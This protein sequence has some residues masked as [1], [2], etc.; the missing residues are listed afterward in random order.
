MKIVSVRHGFEADHS[1]SNYYFFALERLSKEQREAIAALTDRQ[2]RGRTLEF[3]YWGDYSMPW[4][5]SEKLLTMG[6][7]IL[8]SESY[9]WWAVHLSLPY[10]QDLFERIGRYECDYDGNGINV[11]QVG[12]RM[13]VYFGFSMDYGAAYGAMGDDPFDGL[14]DLFEKIRDELLAGDLGAL[15]AVYDVYGYEEE[16]EDEEATGKLSESARTLRSIITR[17]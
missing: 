5:W 12:E 14:A 1:S 13:I 10:G 2:P 4:E 3:Q 9:D 7:D 8:V 17:H 11:R 6:Y 15:Q 16:V